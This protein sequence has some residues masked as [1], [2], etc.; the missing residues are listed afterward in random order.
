ML[1]FIHSISATIQAMKNLSARRQELRLPNRL[2]VSPGSLIL[3]KG[4]WCTLV[5]YLMHRFPHVPANTWRERMARGDVLDDAGIVLASDSPY[6]PNARIHYYRN[7]PAELPIPFE[8]TVLYQDEWI[9]VADKPHF[10]PVTP[11]G[12][13]L[14]ETLLI[15][16][17]RKLGID[18][19][20][21]A[22]RIDLD[23]AGLVLFTVQPQTRNGLSIIVP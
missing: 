6:Q 5:D 19:L 11:S 16:L 4:N 2:G 18:T 10:L 15:R 1:R 21:P 22:H 3:P 7:L 13:F 9:V 14:Q 8:E 17:R 20:S 23:T 12:R